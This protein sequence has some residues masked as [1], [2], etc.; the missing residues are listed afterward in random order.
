MTTGRI[1]QIAKLGRFLALLQLRQTRTRYIVQDFHT[2][3]FRAA[4]VFWVTRFTHKYFF[5]HSLLVPAYVLGKA[6]SEHKSTSIITNIEAIL[7][8]QSSGKRGAVASRLGTDTRFQHTESLLLKSGPQLARCREPT[9]LHLLHLDTDQL[10]AK[11]EFHWFIRVPPR[12]GSTS[13]T[14]QQY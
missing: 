10:Q 12:R 4:G 6:F 1:N 9:S 5:V 8:S 13:A 2:E 3:L 11:A 7:G 14:P